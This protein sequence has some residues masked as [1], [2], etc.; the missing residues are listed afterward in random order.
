MANEDKTSEG[1]TGE[2]AVGDWRGRVEATGEAPAHAIS[3]QE[4]EQV[5]E[6]IGALRDEIDRLDE[7]LVRLLSARAGCALGIG[8]LKTLL[9]MEVYQPKREVAVLAHVRSINRGPLDDDA[10]A[11]LFERIIDEAR[12]LERVGH[13]RSGL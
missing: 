6:R 10:I 5:V 3:A 9:G 11:R 13:E 8:R 2:D 7:E 4:R 1:K 12:R